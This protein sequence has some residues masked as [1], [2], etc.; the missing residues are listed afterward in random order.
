MNPF[1]NAF[2][3]D[4]VAFN[5]FLNY[6]LPYTLSKWSNNWSWNSINGDVVNGDLALK[7]PTNTNGAQ[8]QFYNVRNQITNAVFAN[9]FPDDVNFDRAIRQLS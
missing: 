6:R 1:Y 4:C 8:R 9:M 5:N 7:K 3:T 2:V